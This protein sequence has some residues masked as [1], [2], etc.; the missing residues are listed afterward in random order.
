MIVAKIDS[1]HGSVDDN[2]LVW[3]L[4][5]LSGFI[6]HTYLWFICVPVCEIGSTVGRSS[7][8]FHCDRSLT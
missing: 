2:D 8:D 4:G 5:S 3:K 7:L 1:S 6:V